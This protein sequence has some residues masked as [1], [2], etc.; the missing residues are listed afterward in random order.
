MIRAAVLEDAS[1]IANL[2]FLSMPS[3]WKTSDI[4][5]ALHSPTMVAWVWEEARE[6]KGAILLQI[7][8]DEAEILSIATAK[9]ARR[10]GIGRTLIEYALREMG[11]EVSVFLEV[12]S[13]NSGAIAFYE[14][15]GFSPIG[16]RKKYYKDPSDDALL[17]KFGKF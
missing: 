7:C 13:K 3:P 11:R 6:I 9:N 2:F 15:L 8:M 14:A 4:E 17:M 5:D 12:R 16:M 1:A 10:Q